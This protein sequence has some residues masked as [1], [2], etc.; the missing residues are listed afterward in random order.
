MA[1]QKI[2][3]LAQ[4][5][6]DSADVKINGKRSW[7]IQ[8]KNKKF[9][10]R[11]L[12][13]GS[14][15]LGESYMDGWWECKAIDQLSDRLL[16]AKLDRKIIPYKQLIYQFL[17]AKLIN[18][19]TK[20]KSKIVGEVHYDVGN[21]LYKLML[22]R[23]MNYSCGYWKNAKTLDQ[24]QEAKLDLIC[25]KLKLKKGMTLLDIGCGWGGFAKFVAEKYGAKVL[26]VTISKE[27]AKLAQEICKGLDVEIRLQ[28]YRDIKE[29]F[30][31]VVSIGMFE[32]VGYKNYRKFMKVV[33]NCLKKE[34]LFLLHTIGNNKSVRSTDPWIEKYIFPNS[35]LPSERQITTSSEGIFI[36]EDWHNFGPDYDKTLMQWHKNFNKNW[37][38]IKEKYNQRFFRMWNYYLLICAGVFRSR[39]A[40][41][42][43]IVFSKKS[44]P[45]REYTSIR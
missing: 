13:G 26:G 35:M 29:K 34:G 15:A 33:N 16:R 9:F 30:D 37:E 42:W 11:V 44:S 12:A 31:R 27:Q 23:R 19:Q 7:D 40:Q 21:N 5:I 17:K 43:Q 1:S 39:E 10:S 20:S 18:M 32:H 38:K 4:K 6:L 36:V 8:I 14:L 28:D 45:T 25:K 41:L 22:D 3:Q 24:S 2:N